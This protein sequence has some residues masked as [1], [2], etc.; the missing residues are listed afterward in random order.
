MARRALS[1]AA[2]ASP[3]SRLEALDVGRELLD[4]GQ[5]CLLLLA[6]GLGDLLAEGLLLGA[7][8]FEGPG[9]L[10]PARIGRQHGVDGGGVSSARP[11]GIA[12]GIGILSQEPQ[13]DHCTRVPAQA[14]GAS[15]HSP[16]VLCDHGPDPALP[17]HR[18]DR[19][20][21]SS[22]SCCSSWCCGTWDATAVR[23][24]RCGQRPRARGAR[25]EPALP[26]TVRPRRDVDEAP[27]ADADPH[28]DSPA[29]SI[30]R[31]AV[32]LNPSKF[33]DAEMFRTRV[34]EVVEKLEGAEVV[35]YE[36]TVEDPGRGQTRRA[37]QEG[38]DL[39]VA[40]GGD[41]T[42]RLVS[43]V[44]AG[45]D[46]RMAIIPAGT[47]NLLARNL[48]IPLEDPTAAMTA[49][50]SGKDRQIDVGWLRSGGSV[51]EAAASAEQIFLVIAGFGADA[52][53]IG[54]TDD[55]LKK[56][57]GLDRLCGRRGAHDP[58]PLGRRHAGLPRRHPP[59]PQGAHRAAGQRGQ[60]ARRLRADAGC[61]GGQRPPR[62]RGR[63][64]EGRRRLQPGA[65]GGREPEAG[66]E[67]QV[68]RDARGCPP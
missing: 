14:R 65:H 20:H 54:H 55:T 68:R 48:D 67:G 31:V 30:H 51:S 10:A 59:R 45:T 15:R 7:R 41:G 5:Q 43:S 39:V 50:L 42:V 17:Q 32:V 63:R 26:G 24:P 44:L 60:A 34:R 2:M 38:A 9:R 25:T 47:G 61:H 11:L 35:F 56:R 49:A 4:L 62:D 36:T 8:G 52:E 66:P 23:S 18:L 46:T 19:G 53:M 1:R 6:R 13:I 16:S 33:E 12:D 21:A 22:P 29:D 57:L 40:A 37:L 3:A 64:L 58:G 27:E 28:D